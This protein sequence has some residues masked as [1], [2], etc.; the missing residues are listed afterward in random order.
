MKRAGKVFGR[1]A[2]CLGAL[3][4]AFAVT[5]CEEDGKTA[6]ERCA[7][8][9]LPLFDIRTMPPPSDDNRRFNDGSSGDGSGLPPCITEVGHAVSSFGDGSAGETGTAGTTASG[10]TSASGGSSNGGGSGGGASGGDGGA[11]ASSNAGAGGA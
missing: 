9:P 5:A 11:A 6:P 4:L 2:A 10:G 7:D 3:G 8:P 1:A